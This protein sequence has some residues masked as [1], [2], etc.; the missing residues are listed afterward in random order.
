[1]S[2][3]LSLNQMQR[4]SDKVWLFGLPAPSKENSATGTSKAEN[5]S[6]LPPTPE[7][8]NSVASALAVKPSKKAPEE[9][10]KVAAAVV[11]IPLAR[12]IVDYVR[13]VILLAPVAGS[14]D[15]LRK[16]GAGAAV[17]ARF[18]VAELVDQ[19]PAD[20]P[21][22][23]LEGCYRRM[24]EKAKSIPNEVHAVTDLIGALTRFHSYMRNCH[25]KC[26]LS[27]KGILAP[28]VLLDRVDVDVL[29]CAEHQQLRRSIR[30]R[31]PG[32]RSEDHRNIATGLATLGAAG[33]RREEA[34]LLRISDVHLKGWKGFMV[35]PYDEHTLKS[36]SAQRRI[37]AEVIPAADFE[38]LR[39]WTETRSQF[40]K[41]EDGYLFGSNKFACISPHIFKALNQLIADVTGTRS[42]AHPTHFHHLRRSLCSYGLLRL[43]LPPGCE[44]PEYMSAADRDWLMAGR[45]FRPREIRRTDEPWNSDVFLM[46]QLLGHLQGRTTVSRYFH[47]CGELLRVYLSRSAALSPTAEQL[48]LAI[49][50]GLGAGIRTCDSQSAMNVAVNLLGNLAKSHATTPTGLN[51]R[52]MK[53]PPDLLLEIDQAW[54]LLSTIEYSSAAIDHAADDVGMS[55]NRAKAMV[56]AADYLS[57]LK[58]GIHE[59]RHRFVELA[60]RK[61][62]SETRSIIPVRP[63]QGSDKEVIAQLAPRIQALRGG[64]MLASGVKAY[65]NYLW[66]SKCCP[67]FAK[68]NRGPAIAFLNLLYKLDIANKD[69]RFGSF[70]CRGSASEKEWKEILGLRPRRVFERWQV[71]FAY[72]ASLRPWLGI[73]PTFGQEPKIQSP[74]LFGFRFLM[75]M[76]YIV[77]EADPEVDASA[78]AELVHT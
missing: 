9:L 54:N 76:S 42:G 53:Q 78:E 33:M 8:S 11:S 45:N 16:L 43:L 7:W 19:D 75:V 3:S 46:G 39:V 44:P 27:D 71:P 29:S 67:V 22:D 18:L 41:S 77:L 58:S 20:L 49:G 6:E 1:M 57:L 26:R 17:L 15:A 36:D 5:S 34:R 66:D 63:R 23:E 69:I 72:V 64:E 60:P 73:K 74:G 35:Q 32:T 30:L 61:S 21:D 65:V 59:F 13:S 55:V 56:K 14:D 50:N 31:W 2:H 62:Q 70:D 51:T 25:K 68:N 37:P 52:P 40:L 48:G 28:P 10:N 12:R 24:V 4:I 38:F 47:F